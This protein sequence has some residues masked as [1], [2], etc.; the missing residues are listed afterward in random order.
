ML[1]KLCPIFANGILTASGHCLCLST[2]LSLHPECKKLEKIMMLCQAP[3]DEG[4][5]KQKIYL[6]YIMFEY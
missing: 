2:L 1:K 6:A 3:N 5:K 4:R